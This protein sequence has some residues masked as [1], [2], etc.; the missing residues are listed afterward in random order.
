MQHP[1]DPSMSVTATTLSCRLKAKQKVFWLHENSAAS[2][3]S[4]FGVDL[5]DFDTLDQ[6]HQHW[7]A[8]QRDLDHGIEIPSCTICW[9]NEHQGLTSFRTQGSIHGSNWIELIFSNLCNQQCSYCGPRFSSEWSRSL[10]T[11]GPFTGISGSAQQHLRPSSSTG[12]NSQAWLEQLTEYLDQQPKESVTLKILGGEPLMQIRSLRTWLSLNLSSIGQLRI[13]TNLNPPSNRFLR[14]LLASVSPAKL[15]FDISLDAHPAVNHI[16]RAGFNQHRF[17]NNLN[18][19]KTQG[20]SYKFL[21]V[22]SVLNVFDLA[23]FTHWA[24]A[25]EHDLHLSTI[26]NPACLS[27]AILPDHWKSQITAAKIPPMA[28]DVLATTVPQLDLRLR[29]Q[30]NYLKQYFDRTGTQP[31]NTDSKFVPY[32]Q[33][34]QERF[35]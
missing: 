12:H 30:Y 14:W 16:A 21:T 25:H 3:C 33:W 15:V 7:F 13:N 2:C 28:Q 1:S 26:N 19:L 22:I 17:E 6:L 18:M 23:D 32:W 11:L 34:L 24:N 9:R 5:S 27:P 35:K 8:E 20:F 4:S 29:E 31:E 10:D